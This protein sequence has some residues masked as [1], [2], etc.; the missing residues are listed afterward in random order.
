MEIIKKLLTKNPYSRVGKR[1]Y[2]IK[3]VVIHWVANPGTTADQ[4]R[5]FF[6]LRKFGK[7]GYGSAHFIIDLN[8]DI[9]QCIPTNEMAYHVGASEYTQTALRN[10][11]DY[12]NDCTIGIEFTHPNWIG[13]PSPETYKSMIELT[14]YLLK[15]HKLSALHDLYRHYDV[16]GKDCPR[17]FI[18]NFDKWDDFI[19]AVKDY[20]EE[21]N[22]E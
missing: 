11:S 14:A 1:I 9:Y 20:M 12:P 7:H 21:Q 6:E 16:T 18:T 10:L 19:Y 13:N 8:G 15:K 4:N 22:V 2:K 3:G 17:F 5:V